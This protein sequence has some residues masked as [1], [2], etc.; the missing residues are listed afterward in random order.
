MRIACLQIEHIDLV[1][2]IL[3]LA[4]ALED[5]RL[6]IRRKIA[7]AAAFA[8]V[9]ELAGVREKVAFTPRLGGRQEKRK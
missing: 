2:R 8:L 1:K 4:F 3:S 7:F 5:E 9:G 6:A